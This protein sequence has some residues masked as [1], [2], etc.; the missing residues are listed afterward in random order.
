MLYADAVP[1]ARAD[2]GVIQRRIN[3]EH[4]RPRPDARADGTD[5]QATLGAQ[6]SGT[7]PDDVEAAAKPSP[8]ALSQP[9]LAQPTPSEEPAADDAMGDSPMAQP[10]P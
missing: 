9:L 4:D 10:V 6:S 1:V 2:P 8:S 5:S 3:D 7:T